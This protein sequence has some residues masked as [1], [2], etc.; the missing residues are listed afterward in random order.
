MT[1]QPTVN[2]R[3]STS[4]PGVSI[5]RPLVMWGPT[6]QTSIHWPAVSPRR[7][8]TTTVFSIRW[9]A[10]RRVV[11]WP[12]RPNGV[13]S[14]PAPPRP[15]APLCAAAT[16][17]ARGVSGFWIRQVVLPRTKCVYRLQGTGSI[18]SHFRSESKKTINRFC[19][20]LACL[21]HGWRFVNWVFFMLR[22]PRLVMQ[23]LLGS[24]TWQTHST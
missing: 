23:D 21:A 5:L 18:V 19:P 13:P 12:D 6:H 3:R 11:S 16:R 1:S 15:A 4:A 2:G 22:R 17:P 14:Y 20:R 8:Y 10:R 9:R 24:T 7:T